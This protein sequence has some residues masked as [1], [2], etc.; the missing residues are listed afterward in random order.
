LCGRNRGVLSWCVLGSRGPSIWVA[1]RIIELFYLVLLLTSGVV[2]FDIFRDVRE[3]GDPF[4]EFV[5]LRL[6]SNRD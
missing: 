4:I 3:E 6:W 1:R 2:S 5:L